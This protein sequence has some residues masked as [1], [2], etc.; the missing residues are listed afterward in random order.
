[1][2]ATSQQRIGVAIRW[3]FLSTVMTG[4]L[5]ATTLVVLARLISPSDYGA[6]AVAVA[7]NGLATGFIVNSIERALVVADSV[8]FRGLS[9]SIGLFSLLVSALAFTISLL[10]IHHGWIST[11]IDL[12][13][14]L[15][16]SAAISSTAVP[17]R[18]YLRRNLA[19]GQVALSEFTGV[20]LGTTLTAI[21]LAHL[22]FGAYA[23]VA[24]SVVQN[25][26]TLCVLAISAPPATSFRL[27]RK[28]ISTIRDNLIASPLAMLEIFHGQLPTFML[29]F[30]GASALGIYNRSQ[31][32]VQLPVQLLTTSVSRVMISGMSHKISDRD[33][34]VAA[35][36]LTTIATSAII[37]PINFGIAGSQNAFTMVMLG[38]QWSGAAQL[39]PL[40]ALASWASMTAAVFGSISE[41]ARRFS[42][43]AQLQAFGSLA[44]LALLFLGVRMGL[45]YATIAIVAGALLMA[46]VNLRLAAAVLNVNATELLRWLAPGVAAGVACGLYTWLAGHWGA[47][48]IVIFAMQVFGCGIITASYYIVFHKALVLSALMAIIPSRFSKPLKHPR[49]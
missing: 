21:I 15:L 45:Y 9:G 19:F 10:P 27:T 6:Y 37:G 11:R 47:S 14:T 33:Q 43:K 28:S 44:L 30:L 24:G 29:S 17:P 4:A 26:V 39:I 40:L 49:R 25:I 42:S 13:A 48:A 22:H 20:A 41:S 46:F 36:R 31:A 34:F 38:P 16:F 23:L 35:A 1:M 18:V 8:E 2:T 3:T 7:I 12:L 5:Q 32:I